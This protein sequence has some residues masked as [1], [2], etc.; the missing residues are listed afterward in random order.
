MMA[1]YRRCWI[2]GC[3]HVAMAIGRTWFAII[4]EICTIDIIHRFVLVKAIE[5]DSYQII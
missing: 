4:N 5:F 1:R 3:Q 2:V